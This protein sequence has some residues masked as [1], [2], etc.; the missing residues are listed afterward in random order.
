KAHINGAVAD[1]APRLFHH[2]LRTL[3]H[4]LFDADDAHARFLAKGDVLSVIH[5]APYADLHGALRVEHALLDG[6][7]EGCAVGIFEAAEILVRGV[8]RGGERDQADGALLA[9][10]SEDGKRAEVTAARR[11]R[12]DALADER[13][14]PD[15]DP[16]EPVLD[17]RRIDRAI[18]E[19]GAVRG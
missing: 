11:E 9:D 2:G 19:V 13:L 8:G 7:A 3:F 10:S 5:G 15:F 16:L 4:R 6:A 17:I 18:T 14:E 1:D 12:P